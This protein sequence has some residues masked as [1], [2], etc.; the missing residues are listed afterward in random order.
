MPGDVIGEK[1]CPLTPEAYSVLTGFNPMRV[2]DGSC[3][4]ADGDGMER[5]GRVIEPW[6]MG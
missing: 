6:L 4:G 2:S 3:L 5:L 1:G